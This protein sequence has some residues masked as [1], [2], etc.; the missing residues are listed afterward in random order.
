V[1]GGLTQGASYTLSVIETNVVGI[2]S[3]PATVNVVTAVP[4]PASATAVVAGP[5][6]TV[7][8]PA[9]TNAAGYVLQYK[10]SNVAAWTTFVGT[11]DPLGT[12][13]QAPTNGT[14]N[15]RVAAFNAAVP[16]VSSAFVSANNVTV[17]A[18][19][20]VPA[21]PVVAGVTTTNVTLNW[22]VV[23]LATTYSLYV[24]GA[25]TPVWTGA[26]TVTGTTVARTQG[27]QVAGNA[28]TYTLTANNAIG[29]SVQSAA[30]S[31]ATTLPANPTAPTAANGGVVGTV[32]TVNVTVPALPATTTVATSYVIQYQ[33]RA[34][35]AAAWSALAVAP[36]SGIAASNATQVVAQTF[37]AAGQ[38]RF[39]VVAVNAGGS[40]APSGNSNTVTM[41]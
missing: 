28:Y 36:V 4:A 16:A 6:V 26:G 18:A 15:I 20:A 25:A 14:Y 33:T 9:V 29:S 11:I 40:S 34:N 30:S 2:S 35:A 7:S 17:A 19:P 39:N 23:P 8:W 38:Y 27:G 31:V 32:R 41:P 3:P 5:A 22:P 24:N 37:N 10:R 1:F 21:A 12:T 13:F